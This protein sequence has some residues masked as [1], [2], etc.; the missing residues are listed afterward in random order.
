MD[1]S[2][3]MNVLL[4]VLYVSSMSTNNVLSGRRDVTFATDDMGASLGVTVK[5]LPMDK[6]LQMRR[7]R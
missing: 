6:V 1:A 7:T 2:G 5:G 4:Y 3:Q